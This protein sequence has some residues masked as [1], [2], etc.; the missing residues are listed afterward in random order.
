[1]QKVMLIGNLGRD[2]EVK[3]SQQGTAVAQFSVATMERWKD[4][5]GGL[6]EHTEWFAVKAFNR[7]AEI[8]G[9]H[10]QKGARVYVDRIEFLDLKGNGN[11]GRDHA[12]SV[13]EEIA[14]TEQE[15]PF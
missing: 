12:E 15:T 4:K 14:V 3:Y 7:L 1:M 6:Q 10:L 13:S 11:G 8:A 9:E 2:P 5:Q